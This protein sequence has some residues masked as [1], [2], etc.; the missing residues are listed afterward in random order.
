[1]C[2]QIRPGKPSVIVEARN[3]DIVALC[4]RQ[5]S[6][7]TRAGTERSADQHHD[8]T[9]RK[10]LQQ[11]PGDTRATW[12]TAQSLLHSRQKVIYDDSECADLGGK[13]IVCFSSTRSGASGTTSRRRYSSPAPG[14]LL[15]DRIQE[16]NY[17]FSSR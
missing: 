14:C 3:V 12:R 6:W 1:M 2:C 11:A 17:R 13:L 16:P 5:T 15:H 9:R 10:Q 8:V 7:R 4:C